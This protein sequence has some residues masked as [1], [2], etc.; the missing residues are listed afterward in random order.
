[1]YKRQDVSNGLLDGAQTQN[2]ASLPEWKQLGN[3]ALS[4]FGSAI[5]GAFQIGANIAQEALRGFRSKQGID[6]HSPSKAFER[7]GL[8]SASGFQNGLSSIL[9]VGKNIGGRLVKQFS[10]CL[11]Y[12]SFLTLKQH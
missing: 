11:L 10:F 9:D 5:S 12:T 4:G 2:S 7:L 1:M 8:D 6:S 3:D